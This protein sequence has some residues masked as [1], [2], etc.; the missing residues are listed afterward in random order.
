MVPGKVGQAG[1]SVHVTPSG[2]DARARVS[3]KKPEVEW[4]SPSGAKRKVKKHAPLSQKDQQARLNIVLNGRKGSQ[5]TGKPLPKRTAKAVTS[6][7][8]TKPP[9]TPKN[10]KHVPDQSK[11]TAGVEFELP[12]RRQVRQAGEALLDQVLGDSGSGTPDVPRKKGKSDRV[13]TPRVKIQVSPDR[14]SQKTSRRELPE[15]LG[16]ALE[17]PGRAAHHAKNGVKH[18]SD[19]LKEARDRIGLP[20][21]DVDSPDE[22]E[23]STENEDDWET[24]STATNASDVSDVSDVSDESGYETDPYAPPQLD[25]PDDEYSLDEQE[26]ALSEASESVSS[27][28]SE[29]DLWAR[30]GDEFPERLEKTESALGKLWGFIKRNKAVILIGVGI[31]VGVAACVGIG[32]ATGGIGLGL[33]L[34]AA[35]GFFLGAGLGMMMAADIKASTPPPQPEK[36]EDDKDK[37]EPENST[38]DSTTNKPKTEDIE[39]TAPDLTSTDETQSKKDEEKRLKERLAKEAQL[40]RLRSTDSGYDADD[41]WEDSSVSDEQS[42]TVSDTSSTTTSAQQQNASVVSAPVSGTASKTI[43]VAPTPKSS[44]KQIPKTFAESDKKDIW[45][46]L[47]KND[48]EDGKTKFTFLLN[49]VKAD[50]VIKSS[51]SLSPEDAN[52]L[53]LALYTEAKAHGIPSSYKSATFA[54]KLK[55]YQFN[56]RKIGDYLRGIEETALQ[57]RSKRK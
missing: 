49:A 4:Q 55:D 33:A 43:D 14:S 7:T 22:S 28:V 9:Q 20:R 26:D 2:V 29:D 40:Q 42:E 31:F 36:T 52:E 11:A 48:E 24:A 41:D 10:K 54:K 18:L 3:I 45:L 47:N 19:Q 25:S 35:G 15:A 37:K 1:G 12:S 13:S 27:S 44:L 5:A 21:I 50:V 32:A 38:P 51:L 39:E 6:H 16:N 57:E 34:I 53:E 46:K 30:E 17:L 23:I 8:S 56:N